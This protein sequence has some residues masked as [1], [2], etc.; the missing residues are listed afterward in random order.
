MKIIAVG[1]LA[2]STTMTP[3]IAEKPVGNSIQT[4]SYIIETKV[5][6]PLSQWENYQA[7]MDSASRELASILEDVEQMN[8]ENV[9][10]VEPVLEE[11]VGRHD[12]LAEIVTLGTEGLKDGLIDAKKE[13]NSLQSVVEPEISAFEDAVFR[14]RE[15]LDVHLNRRVEI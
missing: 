7:R 10:Q 8:P 1:F 2:L 3:R 9:V 13:I 11:L 4:A 12:E 5:K 14:L 15:A 6:S